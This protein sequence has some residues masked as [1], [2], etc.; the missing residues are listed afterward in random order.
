M[1]L[2][3]W[4]QLGVGCGDGDDDGTGPQVVAD[5][6]VS[7]GTNTIAALG[8]TV[9]FTAVAKDASGGTIT[10]QTFTWTSSASGV[11]TVNATGLVTAVGNGAATITAAVGR[12]RARRL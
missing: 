11:A 10:G 3:V 2:L 5:V 1:V 9:Q 12:S 8:A 4:A 7:P 6:E